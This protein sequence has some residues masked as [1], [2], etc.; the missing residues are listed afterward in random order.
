M[1]CSSGTETTQKVTE[2]TKKDTVIAA[3]VATAVTEDTVMVAMAVTEDTVM[4]AMAVTEDTVMAAMAVTDHSATA[5]ATVTADTVASGAVSAV[6]MVV[7]TAVDT[8]TGIRNL[9]VSLHSLLNFT[10]LTI[11]C[12]KCR[13]NYYVGV[14]NYCL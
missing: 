5:E 3:T 11:L 2:A 6:T 13:Y 14:V 8:V 9:T 1:S 4:V 10:A 7:T 12:V